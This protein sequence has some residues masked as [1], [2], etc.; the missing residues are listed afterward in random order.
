M[1]VSFVNNL[2]TYKQVKQYSNNNYTD[3]ISFKSSSKEIGA[4]QSINQS[5]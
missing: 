2:N 1:K 4:N 5:F 3:N